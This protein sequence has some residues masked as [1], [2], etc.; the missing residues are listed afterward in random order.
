MS[1]FFCFL[2][3]KD[4]NFGL[5]EE[6]V[7]LKP[8]RELHAQVEGRVGLG[9]FWV[10]SAFQP[11]LRGRCEHSEVFVVQSIVGYPDVICVQPTSSDAKSN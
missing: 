4:K 9:V 1:L 10:W 2:I 3:L 11:R 7:G 5:E 6:C 8:K